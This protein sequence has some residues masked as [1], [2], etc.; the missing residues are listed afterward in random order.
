MTPNFHIPISAKR[1]AVAVELQGTLVDLL[2]LTL[3][4]KHAHWNVEGRL[5]RAVH[6]ELDELVDA[7]RRL[8][9]DVAERAVTIGALPDGQVEAI[10]GATELEALPSGHLS[11]RQ[12]LKAFG[13]RLSD[14]SIRTRQRGERIAVDDPVT[15]DL[16]VQVAATRRSRSSSGWSAPRSLT[17]RGRPG[18]SSRMRPEPADH[19]PDDR[20]PL[21]RGK[22]RLR[23]AARVVPP[24]RSGWASS[25]YLDERP[26]EMR[27]PPPS[28]EAR[29]RSHA[30]GDGRAPRDD[31][32]ATRERHR[33]K[34][35]RFVAA[36][37]RALGLVEYALLTLI[38][39]GVAITAV[40]AIVDP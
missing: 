21:Q 17:P 22:R 40:M 38:A 15:C 12:V 16:L 3:L 24:D 20:R 2:D 26:A 36:T 7:W 4:G 18:T 33:R 34:R 23:G 29:H 5:F 37:T 30:T 35:R 27:R 10:A 6:G 32:V 1:Q 14:A 39:V 8:A 11:D 25:I 19:D 31:I 9:D 28:L 13:D